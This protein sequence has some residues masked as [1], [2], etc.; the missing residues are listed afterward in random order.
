M[1]KIMTYCMKNPYYI[2]LLIICFAQ[3]MQLHALEKNDTILQGKTG[4]VI[5]TVFPLT[6]D[7]DLKKSKY[8]VIYP[9]LVINN[10]Q[11]KDKKM[12]NCFRNHFD[13]MK[14][15]RIKHVTKE[16]AKKI[17]IPSIP[18]DGVLFVTTREGYYFNLSCKQFP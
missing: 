4:P 8:P 18:K 16:K 6:N 5:V 14:I 12:I 10:L 13:R 7:I 17:S 9:L 11:I 3:I 1:V 15:K 2:L